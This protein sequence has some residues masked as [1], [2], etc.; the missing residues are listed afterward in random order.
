MQAVGELGAAG[1]A[2][3][4]VVVAQLAL[5]PHDALRHRRLRHEEG[6]GDLGGVEPAE[7]AQRERHLHVGRQRRVAAQEHEAQLVVGDDVDE[8]VEVLQLGIGRG[9]GV[10]VAVCSR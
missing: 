7:Q 10:H 5:G 4:R 9:V 8:L 6:S 1:H 3:R 2:V